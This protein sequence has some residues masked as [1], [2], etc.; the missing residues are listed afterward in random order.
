MDHKILIVDDKKDI[1]IFIQRALKKIENI[2]SVFSLTPSDALKKLS[3]ESY[4]IIL[5]DYKLPE[6]N[7]LEFFKKLEK[8][9]LIEK[10]DVILM[11]AHGS[12][13]MG[14]EATSKGFFD[15]MTKPFNVEN[16]IFRVKKAIEHLELNEKL[17][18]LSQPIANKYFDLIGKSEAMNKIYRV[19][20]KVADKDATILIEGETGTGKEVVAKAIHKASKRKDK[21]FI[22]VNC[23]ALTETLLESELF[24][25]EKGAFTGAAAKKYGIIETAHNGTVFLDEIN[26]A[27]MNVQSNLLRYIETG[28]FMRVGGTRIITCDARIIAASNKS[29]EELIEENKFREDLYHRLNIIKIVIPPLRNRKDDIPLLTDYFLDMFNKKFDKNV[30]I[31]KSAMN[32]FNEYYW[33]GNVRQ[34]KNL[35]QSLVLLNENNVIKPED[36]P[37][38]IK[39][40]NM[41]SEDLQVFKKVKDKL[42][43]EFEVQYFTKLLQKTKGNVSKASVVANLNRKHLIEKIKNYKI[44]PSLFKP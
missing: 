40:T 17:L 28:E 24:G 14:M 3:K 2:D 39:K 4:D 8:K 29:L 18:V 10:S 31:Y 6:M 44:D 32:Y 33:P 36:M 42:I 20:E 38:T 7:G 1:C 23:G 30:K 35:I 5:V 26:N 22:P 15:Y 9:K 12:I 43:T 37:G 27:S 11:T 21:A 16:L 25:Y 13:K 34:V 19:I 41:L